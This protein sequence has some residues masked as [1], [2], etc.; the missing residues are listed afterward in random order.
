MPDRKILNNPNLVFSDKR[1]VPILEF[2][3]DQFP[4]KYKHDWLP[5][6]IK[7]T[8]EWLKKTKFQGRGTIWAIS[9]TSLNFEN[10][11]VQSVFLIVQGFRESF[12]EFI[13]V[14]LKQELGNLVICLENTVPH[15][16]DGW[17][18]ILHVE[19]GRVFV[20]IDAEDW[21]EK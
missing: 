13:Y 12:F 16:F 18:A 11:W 1:A 21:E 8:K 17:N 4:D 10:E 2:N 7:P 3:I 5:I 19:Q 14:E 9:N 15:E 6:T 20:K